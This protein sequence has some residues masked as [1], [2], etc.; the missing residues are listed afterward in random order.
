MPRNSGRI[1]VVDDDETARRTV[2]R[3]LTRLSGHSVTKSSSALEALGLLESQPF[4][5]AL[6]DIVMPDMGGIELAQDLK[7]R[8]PAT[9]VIMMTGYDS[10]EYAVTAVKFATAYLTKPFTSEALLAAVHDALLSRRLQYNSLIPIFG[11]DT[12]GA[13]GSDVDVSP[14]RAQK[15]SPIAQIE[16]GVF[17]LNLLTHQLFIH[18]DCRPTEFP[19]SRIALPA[20]EPFSV[21]LTKTEQPIFGSLLLHAPHTMTYVPLAQLATGRDPMSIRAAAEFLRPHIF[22]LRM[23]IEPDAKKPRHLITVRRTGYR[24]QPHTN[25]HCDSLP[26]PL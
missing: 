24:L 7:R 20:P 5:L 19:G 4:D 15:S 23:K 26:R 16:E 6:L 11:T 12:D 18:S 3:I 21:E 14:S 10:H 9:S 17:S 25:S 13:T 8:W 22:S 2:S 1:L